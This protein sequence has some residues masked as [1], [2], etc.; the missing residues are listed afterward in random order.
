MMWKFLV[1]FVLLTYNGIN[2]D[3]S[4]N[5]SHGMFELLNLF[6]RREMLRLMN[7]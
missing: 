5:K 2:G 6:Y 1:I 3:E 4:S 7:F